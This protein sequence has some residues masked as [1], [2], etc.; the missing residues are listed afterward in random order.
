MPG[1]WSTKRRFILGG[2]FVVI[3]ALLAGL[4][5]WKIIYKAPTCS[6]GYKNGEETGI[7]CGGACKNLCTSDTLN[8]VVLWSKV[9]NISGDIYSAVAYIEN[10]N[11]NSKNLKVTY[12][13]SIF[14]NN[15]NLI[16]VKDGETTIPKG[17]KFAVFE[18][19]IVLKGSK[20][21][22]TDFKFITFGPWEKDTTK[23]PDLTVKYSTLISTTT[24]PKITGTIS[25]ESLQNIP[26]LE[27][28]V[29]VI[30]G[31]ENVVA[32]SN[33]F[34]D[35]LL[36]HSSQDFVFTWPKPFDLG[37]EAC[38]SP[39]DISIALDKSGSMM[40]E[41]KNPPEP[42]TTVTNTAKDFIKN[43]TLDDQVSVISFGTLSRVESPLS[44]DRQAALLA[45]SGLSLSTTTLEQTNITGGLSD[46]LAQL[47]SEKARPDSKKII[48]LLTDGV[49]TEPTQTGA[50][51]YPLTSAQDI[52]TSIKA[53]GIDLYTIGLGKDIDDT[54]LKSI[55]SDDNHYFNAP[56]KETL[57]S[58]Y[59]K[60]SKNLCPKKPNV[61]NVIYRPSR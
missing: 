45:V 4:I 33:T 36:K 42:F 27:L 14:D 48:I 18:T 3:A 22:T 16:T 12:Q 40:S 2:T 50:P 58:V 10:P 47:S 55:S 6:D 57:A 60:I 53:K 23:E 39:V 13:F 41:G 26:G 34:V 49:P 5:F 11:L 24:F 51:K 38:V 46:S 17:K 37:V 35:D 25:N 8:P 52:A 59:T 32:A 44:F 54:F 61:I 43:L 28:A 15:G 21:K 31:N 56:S 30:D 7:D 1:S 19:G 29:F 9:F 20:P